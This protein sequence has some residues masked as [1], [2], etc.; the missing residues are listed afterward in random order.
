MKQERYDLINEFIAERVETGKW[1]I[2]S[3]AGTIHTA[4]G[5]EIGNTLAMNGYFQMGLLVNGVT[6][7]IHKHEILAVYAGLNPVDLTINHKD[8]NKLNNSIHNLE[9]ITFQENIQHAVREGKPRL[10]RLADDKVREIKKLLAVD[11]PN[12][13]EISRICEVAYTTVR[14]IDK[15]RRYKGVCI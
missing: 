15:G 12:R 9:V 11:S 5:K 3:D 10:P 8:S 6:K 13:C 1:I 14:A 7:T 2:N 4:K